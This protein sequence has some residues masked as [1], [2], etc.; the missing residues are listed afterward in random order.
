MKTIFFWIATAVL[1]LS[2]FMG[3]SKNMNTKRTATVSTQNQFETGEIVTGYLKIKNALVKSDTKSAALGAKALEAILTTNNI[4]QLNESQKIALATILVGA[5]KEVKSIAT[6]SSRLDNQRKAFQK[7]SI[8]INA[9]LTNFGSA[10]KL[11][12]DFCPMY[13]G[14]AIWISETQNIKNPFYGAQMLTC[15]R[16]KETIK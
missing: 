9:L 6:N 16:I 5:T 1:S 10:Q 7:L 3:H 13:E 14:G 2:A 11:Y 8:H 15:G 4:S 12:V